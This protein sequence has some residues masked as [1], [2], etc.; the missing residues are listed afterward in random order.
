ME[1]LNE[2]GPK[3]ERASGGRLGFDFDPAKAVKREV[4]GGAAFDVAI[5]TRPVFDE[6]VA[7]GK[8]LAAPCGDFARCGLGLP[9]RKGAAKPDIATADA[10]K[11]A[12]IA[13]NR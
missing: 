13:A 1:V 2:L 9:V 8:I 7:Q 11:R 4:E 6:M 12:L 3:F 5:M 10:F